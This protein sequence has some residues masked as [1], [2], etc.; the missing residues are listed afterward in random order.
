MAIDG[1]T[2][3]MIHSSTK[4]RLMEMKKAKDITYDEL[5]NL[6]IEGY[7]NK[8]EMNQEVGEEE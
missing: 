7:E 3:L 1:Y 2:A 6:L 4:E 8:E 5:I